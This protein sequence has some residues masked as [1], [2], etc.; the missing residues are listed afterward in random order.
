[1]VDER[2]AMPETVAAFTDTYLP[3][4]NGASY[5]ISQWRDRWRERGG[6]MHV[7]YPKADGHEP[8]PDE[9]PVGSLPFP[10]YDGFRLGTPRIPRAVEDADLVHCH[11]PFSLGMAGLRLARREGLPTVVSYH[12]PTGEYTDYISPTE[13]VADGLQE[14]SRRW[15]R[16]FLERADAVVAPSERTRQHLLDTID[17]GAPIEV[18]PNG[19]DTDLFRPVDPTGFLQRHGVDPAATLVGYTGR[20]GYEKSL[21]ELVAAA[22]GLDATLLFGGDGPARESLERQAAARDVDARFLGFLDREELP[23]FYAS[24][25]VFGFPSPVETEGMVAL[26]AYACGTPVVGVDS[27]ALS[28]TVEEGVTGYQYPAGDVDAFRS[29]IERAL[30]EREC[31]RENCLERRDALSVEHSVDRLG[32]LYARL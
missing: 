19:V 24:L 3:T 8:E 14:V 20:Q 2:P 9:H 21:D 10:F 29:A 22:D 30:E 6:C 25:D 13:G 15:E 26:E 12:T 23:A 16:L 18:I 27:G 17:V 4:V 1:V 11:T 28:D 5:A 32:E 31:L 7:V